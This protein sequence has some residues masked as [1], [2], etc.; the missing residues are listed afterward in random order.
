MI[1]DREALSARVPPSETDGRIRVVDSD[2]RSLRIDSEQRFDRD[3]RLQHIRE[4]Q[5]V[6]AALVWT[7]ADQLSVLRSSS[8]ESFGPGT[9]PPHS[10][11]RPSWRRPGGGQTVPSL[12]SGPAGVPGRR[13]IGIPPAA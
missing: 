1:H 7:L 12:T 10:I 5:H 9:S 2:S 4:T 11:Y 3:T 13:M 8:S 6:L